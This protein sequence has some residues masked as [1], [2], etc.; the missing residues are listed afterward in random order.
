MQRLICGDNIFLRLPDCSI[1]PSTLVLQ[2]SG[3]ADIVV[4]AVPSDDAGVIVATPASPPARGVWQL[5]ITSECGCYHAQIAVE[6]CRPLSFA[7]RHE[8]VGQQG[9]VQV[10]CPE[11][12][13][14]PEP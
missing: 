1:A 14:E 6:D 7:S 5:H 8:T 13:P 4:T 10:C 2:R 9:V 12:E 3:F 11:P